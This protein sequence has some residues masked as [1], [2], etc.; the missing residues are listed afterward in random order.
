MFVIY[1]QN[2]G[3]KISRLLGG[4]QIYFVNNQWHT[5]CLKKMFI[6]CDWLVFSLLEK[7]SMEGQ[8]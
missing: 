6:S 3:L 5:V 2:S 1:I 4:Y 7:Q 8:K